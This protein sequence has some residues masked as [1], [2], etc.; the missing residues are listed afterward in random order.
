MGKFDGCLLACDI[1]GTL[2]SGEL[3]PR[4]NIEKIDDFVNE[5][6]LFSLSTGRTAAALS[7]ITGKIKT[8]AP[9]VLSNGCVIYDFKH[10]KPMIQKCL[11][12]NSLNVVSD[13]L[14]AFDIGIEMHS[15]DRIFVPRRSAATDLHESYE[16]MTAEFV[17]VNEARRHGINKVI[18]FVEYESRYDLLEKLAKKYENECVFYRT[19]TF[20]EGVK[21]NYF[22][23][24]PKGI[25]KASAIVELCKILNIKKGGYF[26]IGDYYND[27]PMLNAADISAAP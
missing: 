25:S 13:V 11:S 24:L 23:Q 10:K 12:D 14:S 1:D 18:Y 19:C 8:I 7:M 9:S 21:Q 2:I 6:G 17:S 3:L 16:R 27:V 20:I 15:A 4:R 26:A 22:E 5:G